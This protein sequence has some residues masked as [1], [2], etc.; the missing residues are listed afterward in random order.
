MNRILVV[1]DDKASARTLQLHLQAQGY[2][3]EIAHSADT[4]VLVLKRET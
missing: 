4:T 1:D 3:T 2:D